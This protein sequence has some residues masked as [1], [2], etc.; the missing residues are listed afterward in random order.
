M[1]PFLSGWG[2]GEGG[3]GGR[4]VRGVQPKIWTPRPLVFFLPPVTDPINQQSFLHGQWVYV[5]SHAG[6]WVAVYA[7]QEIRPFTP[8]LQCIMCRVGQDRIWDF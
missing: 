2:H 6:G 8:N 4:G 3:I 5:L 7:R 1:V